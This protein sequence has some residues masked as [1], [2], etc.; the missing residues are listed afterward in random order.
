[1]IISFFISN[2]LLDLFYKQARP[3]LRYT[4]HAITSFW[5]VRYAR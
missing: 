5:H 2:F 4:I 1:M 3:N